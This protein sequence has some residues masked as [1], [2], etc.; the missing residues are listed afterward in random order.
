MTL[1]TASIAR[2][3]TLNGLRLRFKLPLM[4]LMLAMLAAA[5]VGF[6]GYSA[7]R[8]NLS[9]SVESR[10]I[11]DAS[12]EASAVIRRWQQL[13]SEI[14][15]QSSNAFASQAIEEMSKWMELGE[16]DR[17]QIIDYYQGGG[18]LSLDERLKL[19][20]RAHRHGYSWRHGPVH[21]T[22]SAV[23]TK[24]G[25]DDIY[26]VSQ[27][28][29]I[30]YSATKG[31]E[32]G[33]LITD[34]VIKGSGL[35]KVAESANGAAIGS[36]HTADF[37]PYIAAG[38]AQRAFLAQ[39]I[40]EGEEHGVATA[41]RKYTGTLV[42]SMAPRV[43]DDVMSQ[44]KGNGAKARGFLVSADGTLRSDHIREQQQFIPSD[45]SSALAL[46]DGQAGTLNNKAGETLILSVRAVPVIPG[47]P[48]K[49]VVAEPA[50][51]AYDLVER[52]R[53]AMLQASVLVQIPIILLAIWIGWSIAKPI[54]RLAAALQGIAS[55]RTLDAIPA[56]DRR[57]EIGAI[58]DAVH[59][60]R[61]N[62]ARANE[63]REREQHERTEEASIQRR[64]ILAEVADD[65]DRSIGRIATAVSAAAEELNAT[66]RELDHG[67]NETRASAEAMSTATSRVVQNMQGIDTSAA[68]LSAAFDGV[69]AEVRRADKVAE[70]ARGKASSTQEIVRRLDE[71]A[72]RVSDVVGLISNVAE[73]TNLLALN[74]TIEAA[75]AGEAGRGFAVVAAE[76]KQLASQT[77]KATEEISRQISLMNEA[78][79]SSVQA[80]GD[81]QEAIAE[82]SAATR[83]TATTVSDQKLA[84]RTIVDDVNVVSHEIADIS[85]GTSQVGAASGQTFQSAQAVLSAAVELGQ[86]AAELQNRV[87]SV[88]A[89]VRAA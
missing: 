48:W 44:T 54:S 63:E 64:A 39:P 30:V 78:T 36:R 52:V 61:D 77:A 37:A 60:I 42:F 35:A 23:L 22:Y 84:S 87:E 28:G 18:K 3:L 67:A 33:Q 50:S 53:N 68:A 73:Q 19:S 76:V 62:M 86:Q 12:S 46:N 13:E 57:D 58:A 72:R 2:I 11:A 59:L 83:R 51:T 89:R 55:G 81:I 45:L 56:R 79:E 71:G 21:D 20:G 17:N 27:T 25:Y 7:V 47:A 69:D 14:D 40:Y 88:I 34:P 70:L 5:G 43:L 15:V 26:L 31:V 16:N 6:S 32:L 85:A 66:A 4:M 75:R 41:K 49:L 1:K 24:F 82:L 8:E 9:K 38:G 10:L 65:L 74:A 29:R 80:I